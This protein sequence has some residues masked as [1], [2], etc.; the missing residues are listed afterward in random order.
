MKSRIGVS[1]PKVNGLASP[2]QRHGLAQRIRI[3]ICYSQSDTF[4]RPVK[5][6]VTANPTPEA[7]RSPQI[8]AAGFSLD[9]PQTVEHSLE[10][11]PS[12]PRGAGK[13]REPIDW[14]IS[15][16]QDPQPEE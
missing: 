13:V 11:A 9:K 4:C 7:A 10:L 2:A 3:E 15:G 12:L 16:G 14:R 5:I 6:R 8:F 1:Q